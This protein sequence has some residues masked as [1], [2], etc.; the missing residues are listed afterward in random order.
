MARLNEI[1]VGRFG[2]SLQKHFGIK[3]PVPV[4]TLA[5]E[6]IPVINVFSGVETRYTDA[7][8]RFGAVSSLAALAGN[9]TLGQLRNPAGSNIIAVVE[10]LHL[11]TSVAH[12]LTVAVLT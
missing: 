4:A 5:P 1:L 8:N 10:L 3:G 9:E 2:R 12:I 11:S 7:W 6:I